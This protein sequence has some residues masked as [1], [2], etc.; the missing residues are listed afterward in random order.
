MTY[1]IHAGVPPAIRPWIDLSPSKSI[2]RRWRLPTVPESPDLTKG[3]FRIYYN[4]C[5]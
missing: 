5:T 4:V 1:T 2:D 3:I